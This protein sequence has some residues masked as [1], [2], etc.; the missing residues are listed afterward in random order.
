MARGSPGALSGLSL[1]L[2]MISAEAAG[3]AQASI[4]AWGGNGSGQCSTP[5]LPAFP[6]ETAAGYNHTVARLN[7]GSV[8][9]WGYNF[10][11]QCNVPALPAGLTFVEIAAG[12]SHTVA[13][14]SDGSIVVWGDNQY[15]NLNVPALPTGL[16]YLEVAA[17]QNHTVALRSDGWVVA[18][19]GNY[20]GQCNVPT[21]PAGVTYVE[22]AAGAEHTVARRSDDIVVAWGSNGDGQCNVPALPAGV[23]YIA[24]AAGGGH[25]VAL[26][27]DGSVAAWGFNGDG[28]C[29]VPPLPDG[30]AYVEV[31][32]GYR[33]TVARRSDGSVVAWGANFNGQCNVPALPAGMSYG[34]VDAGAGHTV[35]R[36]LELVPGLT[37]VVQDAAGESPIVGASV[38]IDSQQVATTDEQGEYECFELGE[39]EVIV[40]VAAYGFN[41]L[42]KTAMVTV[43]ATTVLNFDLVPT[44]LALGQSLDGSNGEPVLTATGTLEAGT[45]LTLALSNA[46]GFAPALLIV[47]LTQI[48]A[49]F[50][51]GVMVPSPDLIFPLFT[52]FFGAVSFGGPWP[53]GIPSGFTTYF[54]W[55]IQDPAGPKG[56]AASNAV[57][58]TT[59]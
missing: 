57:L 25:T 15:G 50:K 44:F 4:V 12:E 53:S 14:R 36:A 38:I 19:G 31:T 9:A 16:S 39:G 8:L 33:H 26:R 22:V 34:E 3:A 24:A 21:L 37:G 43:G 52:D 49:P 18:W 20:V 56:F 35:A 17:G 27:S 28:Q 59:P 45:L 42:C 32:A 55:W 2:A 30:I 5:T 6:V 47:G 7:D 51:G 48:H 46:R 29:N 41:P 58:G 54:Q 40:T 23:T 1:V 13:R 10:W 11:G